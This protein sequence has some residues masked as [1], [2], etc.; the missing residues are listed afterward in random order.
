MNF[1]PDEAILRDCCFD[2]RAHSAPIML[3]MNESESVKAVRSAPHDARDF[4]IG[5]GVVR[6]KCGE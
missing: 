1:D 5:Y 2:H 6:M 3:R 4:P